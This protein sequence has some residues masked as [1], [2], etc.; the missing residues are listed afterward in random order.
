M[1]R[2]ILGHWNNLIRNVYSS[3]GAH[4]QA[5]DLF[6]SVV[7]ADNQTVSINHLVYIL[8]VAALEWFVKK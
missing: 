5:L 8:K 4:G 1:F 3:E 2:K 6:K 7:F